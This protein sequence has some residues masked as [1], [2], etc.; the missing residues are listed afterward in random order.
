MCMC[1]LTTLVFERNGDRMN[2]KIAWRTTE[3]LAVSIG[4]MMGIG[5]LAA[6]PW[7]L[8]LAALT[9]YAGAW[10]ATYTIISTLVKNGA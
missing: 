6:F 9:T 1:S 5:A 7:Y 4:T 3:I 2:K 8:I 10:G